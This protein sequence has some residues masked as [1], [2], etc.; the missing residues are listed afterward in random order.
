MKPITPKEAMTRSIPDAV[1]ESFNELILENING[2][3]AEVLQ[4]DVIN[5]IIA[6]F[7]EAGVKLS[8]SDIFSRNW[9]NIE[10]MYREAGWLV[11]Y[12]KPDYFEDWKAFF[13]F[14]HEGE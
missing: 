9:L 10:S 12:H 1:I 13:E 6:K 3:R 4:D 8:R 7:E 14:T 2:N 11:I 5:A